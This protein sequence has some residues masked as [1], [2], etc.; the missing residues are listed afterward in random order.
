MRVRFDGITGDCDVFGLCTNPILSIRFALYSLI[1]V[2]QVVSQVLPPQKTMPTDNLLVSCTRNSRLPSSPC[3]ST[4]V[5]FLLS[6]IKR[7]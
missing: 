2:S 1:E 5:D 3:T 7:S 4:A 6:T